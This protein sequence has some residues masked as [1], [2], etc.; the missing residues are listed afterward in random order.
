MIDRVNLGALNIDR[1]QL[2]NNVNNVSAKENQVSFGETLKQAIEQV[3]QLD[4]HSSKMGELLAAGKLEHIHDLT[5]AGAKA[6]TAI[7]LT[8]HVRNKAVEAYQEIMRMSV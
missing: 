4:V 2:G 8:A 3:N 6:S 7:E 1:I 5:I